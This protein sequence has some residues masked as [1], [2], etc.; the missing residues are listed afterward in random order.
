LK[1]KWDGD[2]DPLAALAAGDP[3]LFELF[4]RTETGTLL[5]FFR[6]LGGSQS[7]I[8]DLV[9]DTVVKLF[10]SANLYSAND[11][12]EAYA[13]RA[14]RNVWIDSRRRAGVRG[15]ALSASTEDDLDLLRN[16][17]GPEREPFERLE[18]V[19]RA[20]LLRRAVAKLDE[21]HRIAFELGV[22]QGL[23]YSDVAQIIGIPVG[24]VKSRVHNAVGKLRE[25]LD[26][27][28]LS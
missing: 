20:E 5:G 15:P 18:T 23:P 16:V 1:K 11:R 13:F 10:R 9:Q 28:E 6:R 7:E 22:I 3:E 2:R 26:V 12:F 14:A 19:E 4:V 27:E 24:T 21:A 17:E 8:E 25:L